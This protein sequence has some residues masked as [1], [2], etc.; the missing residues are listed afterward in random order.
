VIDG[1]RESVAAVVAERT[2]GL[3]A[4]VVVICAPDRAAHEQAPGLARKGGAISLFASLPKGGAD[5]TL[6]SRLLHYGELRVVGASDSRPEHV[7]RALALL[8]AGQ[9]DWQRVITHRL[10][11]SRLLEGIALMQDKQ[12]LKVLIDPELTVG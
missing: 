9:I 7:S 2:E 1:G 6:D 5:V 11:L 12:S 3:G 8:A 4:D 10:P